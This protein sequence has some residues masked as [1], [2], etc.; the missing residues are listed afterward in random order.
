MQC[1][2]KS[3]LFFFQ[4]LHNKTKNQPNAANA[5]KGFGI[6]YNVWQIFAKAGR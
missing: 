3:P 6:A 5:R 1:S 4:K 2:K